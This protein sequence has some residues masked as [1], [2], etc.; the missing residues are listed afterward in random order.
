MPVPSS[1]NDIPAE[2]PTARDHVGWVWY[3]RQFHCGW[4]TETDRVM[5]RFGSVHYT[6][7]VW[8]NAERTARYW[9]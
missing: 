1:Y 7:K 3:D 4:D 8:I 2:D 5:L 6:A 9:L